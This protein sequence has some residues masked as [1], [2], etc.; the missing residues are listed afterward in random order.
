MGDDGAH[1]PSHVEHAPAARGV[2][3]ADRRRRRPD[4]DARLVPRVRV[5][6]HLL[7]RSPTPAT[8]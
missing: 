7:A 6:R 8:A 2:H 5:L 4:G 1:G 3:R